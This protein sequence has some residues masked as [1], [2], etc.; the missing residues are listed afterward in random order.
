MVMRSCALRPAIL[1]DLQVVECS[2]WFV[3]ARCANWWQIQLG[4]EQLAM[5]SGTSSYLALASAV[6]QQFV[7][8]RGGR[9]ISM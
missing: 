3:S 5:S 2:C 1:F 8:K 4:V 6:G 7:D 9:V